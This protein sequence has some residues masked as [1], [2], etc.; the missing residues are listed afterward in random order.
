MNTLR[1]KD[2]CLS[3]LVRRLDG[4][5]D[6]DGRRAIELGRDMARAGLTAQDVARIH[7]AAVRCIQQEAPDAAVATGMLSWLADVLVA[8]GRSTCAL[9]DS[10]AEDAW[11][12]SEERLRTIFNAS[13]DAMIVID[14]HGAIALFNPAAQDMFGRR[15]VEMIGQPLD[16]LMPERY[17]ARHA[18]DVTS[19]FATGT[20]DGVIGTTIDAPGVRCDGTEFPMEVSLSTGGVGEDAFVLGVLRDITERHQADQELRR[21]AETQKVLLREVNHRVKNNLSAIIGMLQMEE[22]RAERSGIAAYL[23]VL[24]DLV[25]RVQGLATVHHLLSAAG[26]RPL[27]L[28]ALCREVIHASLQSSVHGAPPAVFVM[29][30]PITVN[31]RQAHHLTLVINELATNAAKHAIGARPDGE[32]R[33]LIS[34]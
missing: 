34:A 26:W 6:A 32:V 9:D 14:S 4:E 31:S 7:D 15:G 1:F 30:S 24:R 29:E 17:R 8:Y 11:R 21:S 5:E 28:D 12:K 3:L 16:C 33:V 23:P 18:R 10:A 25:G 20:P 27:Q 2:A 19:F 13:K 22:D